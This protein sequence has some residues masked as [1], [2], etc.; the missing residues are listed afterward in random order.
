MKIFESL[1]DVIYLSVLV[2]LG[3]RLLLEKTKGANLFG[4]MAIVLG[5]G[6]GFHLLPRVISHL[7]PGGF[8]AHAAALSWGQFVTSI[9]MTIFYVLYYHY[10]RLQSNDTDN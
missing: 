6:D 2:A 1:F 10:Y 5:L 4:I 9:T 3:V 8:E 7:S